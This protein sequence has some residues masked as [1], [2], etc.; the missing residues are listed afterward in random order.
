MAKWKPLDS[1]ELRA[2]VVGGLDGLEMLLSG[3]IPD[4]PLNAPDLFYIV[5]LIRDAA[6]RAFDEPER[7][8]PM[9]AN[10]V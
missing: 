10:D 8:Y 1:E 9:E 5:G 7:G 6:H 3:Q 2:H 4:L